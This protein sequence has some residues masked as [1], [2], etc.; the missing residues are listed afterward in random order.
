MRRDIVTSALAIVLL[1]VL[2]GV[3][4]P[5]IVTGVGQGLFP[6]A[7]NGSQVRIG[8]RL[9][10]SSLIGQQYAHPA[11]GG[12]RRAA[13]A[14]DPR[15]FQG[16]P[17]ATTPA[18]DAAASSFSNL[19]PNS[20]TTEQGDARRIREYLALN[21]PYAHGLTAAKVP[22]DA[23]NT[24][25]S[26]LDPEISV[27]NADIQAHRVAALRGLPLPQVMK[28]VSE[29]TRGRLLGFLGEPGVN[30]L[31]LNIALRR[32]EAGR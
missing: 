11:E 32:L 12:G 18:Y 5:L 20:K 17:S 23:V 27:A 15:Y 3:V 8:G 6:S 28:L 26:G 2:T 31:E 25:A 4:Y 9:I 7:A 16:R 24:S 29:H 14:V 21:A 10:G 30:V 1:T 13:G 22:V 19:G